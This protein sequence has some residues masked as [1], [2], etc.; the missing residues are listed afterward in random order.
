M[1]MDWNIELLTQLQQV[2]G[3]P[4]NYRS[5]IGAAYD[6]TGIFCPDGIKGIQFIDEGPVI[7]SHHPVLRARAAVFRTRPNVGDRIFIYRVRTLFVVNHVQPDIHGG[8]ILV[9]NEV[10]TI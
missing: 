5:A 1:G 4:V 2:F 8:S 7:N 10:S 9:L 3:E 6:M